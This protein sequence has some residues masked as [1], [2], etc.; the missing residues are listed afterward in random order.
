MIKND[1]GIIGTTDETV[2]DESEHF[3]PCPICG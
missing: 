3:E 1:L 2:L